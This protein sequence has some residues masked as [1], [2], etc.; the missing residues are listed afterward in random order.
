VVFDIKV[1]RNNIFIF[2]LLYYYIYYCHKSPRP[3]PFVTFRNN[4]IFD[5]EGLFTGASKEVGLEVNAEKTKYM[6]L[7]PHQNPGEN[8]DIHS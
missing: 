2:Q 4:L 1:F 6:L 8:H 3:R 7:S 5:G